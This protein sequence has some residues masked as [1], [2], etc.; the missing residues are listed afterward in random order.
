MSIDIT[1]LLSQSGVTNI[2]DLRALINRTNDADLSAAVEEFS[3]LL[4]DETDKLKQGETQSAQ[5]SEALSLIKALDKSILGNSLSETESVEM[6]KEWSQGE[7][8]E[9]LIS[10]LATGH[11]MGIALTSSSEDEDD[12]TTTLSSLSTTDNESTETLADRLEG[13]VASLGNITAKS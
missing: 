5:D 7:R 9:E 13:I 11:L 10:E 6:V 12:D 3:K 1:S 2:S 8:S 4:T